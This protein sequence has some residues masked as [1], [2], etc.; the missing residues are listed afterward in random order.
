MLYS[1]FGIGI[2]DKCSAACE[3]C[4]FGCSPEGKRT[5]SA[6]M[7]KDTIRQASEMEGIRSVG[8]SGGEAFLYFDMVLDCTSYAKSLGL[9]VSANT[10]GFWGRNEERASEMLKA[11]KAAG[12]DLICFSTDCYHQEYVPLEDLRTA[13]RLTQAAGIQVDLNTMKT[14][15]DGDIVNVM[16]GLRP[17]IYDVTVAYYPM[18]PVGKALERMT[19]SDFVDSIESKFAKCT[20]QG[21]VTLCF[22]G[23]YYMC[24]SQ[25]CM[26]IPRLKL[27]NAKEIALKDVE[28]RILSDD[29]M[30]VMLRNGF[31]W[32]VD[33]A[34]ALG[35]D[36]PE[37]VCSACHCC[38]LIFN[39]QK[40]LDDLR[41]RVTEEAGRLRI[42][43]ILG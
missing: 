33:Q 36:I 35:Y 9:K 29:Y 8:F 10:N 25:F 27:G 19:E 28:K 26:D 16:E 18:L 13:I 40:L 24:C 42:Q 5:L 14:A 38:Y 3:M 32:Y 11:L 43:H 23:Y 7:I 41:E 39:N 17:E 34:R 21:I 30:Y 31:G 12:M 37:R 6:E 22:D 2:T 15:H 20:Y 4:C 1:K